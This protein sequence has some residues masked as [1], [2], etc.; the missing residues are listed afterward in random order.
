M[1]NTAFEYDSGDVKRR[2]V[3]NK[4]LDILALCGI[5]ASVDV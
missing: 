4:I 1:D 5:Y 2:E 3:N